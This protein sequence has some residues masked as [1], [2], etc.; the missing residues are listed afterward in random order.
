MRES[1][2]KKNYAKA[3]KRVIL[4]AVI[5]AVVSA[6]A[7]PLS[8]SRPIS[9]LSALEQARKEETLPASGEHGEHADREE[10][11]KSQITLLS[12]ANYAIL[13]G[14]AVLWLVLLVYYWLLV[15]AWLYKNA[16]SEGMSQSLWP[17]LGLFT[18]LLAV[19]A[20]LIVRDD[21][22]RRKAAA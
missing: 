7:I 2:L 14:I 11:W 21:P 13:G 10:L 1:I 22:R 9:D 18:N 3:F 15:M 17:I 16:L 5:L 20:F 4:L 19:L 12:A 6:A 8:L